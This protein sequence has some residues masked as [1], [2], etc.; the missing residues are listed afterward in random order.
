LLGV[1]WLKAGDYFG[2]QSFGLLTVIAT[3]ITDIDIERHA[4]DFR[5]GVNCQMRLSEDNRA[6]DASRFAG[7]I[8][9]TVKELANDSQAMPFA[10][11]DTI[12]FQPW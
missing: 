1:L 6:G 10:G 7:G 2:E 9:E 8:I 3:E 4:G 12:D 5:P 11:I